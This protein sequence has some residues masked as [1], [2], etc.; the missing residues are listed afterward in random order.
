MVFNIK[1]WHARGHSIVQNQWINKQLSTAAFR[2]FIWCKCDH[3]PDTRSS[4]SRLPFQVRRGQCILTFPDKLRLWV[5]VCVCSVCVCVCVCVSPMDRRRGHSVRGSDDWAADTLE[6]EADR[7]RNKE[8]EGCRSLPNCQWVIALGNTQT[9]THT[10]THTAH[11]NHCWHV[12]RAE[13]ECVS[14]SVYGL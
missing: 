10:C 13:A 3:T 6:K 4:H 2:A 11:T 9:D 14:A 7:R 1:T 8:R 5:T 12:P